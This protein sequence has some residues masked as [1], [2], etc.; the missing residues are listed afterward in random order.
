MWK[1]NSLE[2]KIAAGLVVNYGHALLSMFRRAKIK[3]DNKVL[4]TVESGGL[5]LAALDIAANVYKAKVRI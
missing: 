3:K 4:V 5:G 2:P 1:Y